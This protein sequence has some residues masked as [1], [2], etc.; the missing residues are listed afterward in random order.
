M[1]GLSEYVGGQEA[2]RHGIDKTGKDEHEP[3]VHWAGKDSR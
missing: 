3:Q 1:T 2:S